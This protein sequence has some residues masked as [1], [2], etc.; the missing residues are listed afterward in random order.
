VT[1]KETN[2]WMWWAGT[3]E[4][5]YTV[6]P[7]DTKE[8]AINEMVQD[9]AGELLNDADYDHVFHVTEAKNGPLMLR[10]FIRADTLLEEATEQAYNSDRVSGEYD[11]DVFAVTSEKDADLQDRIK[12]V[13]DDW[14]SDH[15]LVFKTS[16]FETTRNQE[17]IRLPKTKSK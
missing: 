8:Q 9:G 2:E 3:S 12:N 13:C 4:E 16:T 7:C 14:Q 11:D 17:V 6:G 1:T 10:D 15:G 5:W